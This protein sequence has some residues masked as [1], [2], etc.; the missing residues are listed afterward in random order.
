SQNP[1][2]RVLEIPKMTTL[3]VLLAEDDDNDVIL[4]ETAFRAADISNPLRVT[5]DGQDAIDYLSGAGKFSDRI[6]NPLPCL[7]ILDL[8]MPRRTGIEVLEW[9]RGCQGL[10]RIPTVFLSSSAHAYDVERAYEL[11][12]NGFLVKPASVKAR[13]DL[14]RAIKSFWLDFN[15]PP[16]I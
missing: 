16:A 3:P 15:L 12:A 1:R 7:I 11:G 4:L 5:R 6:G 8:K 13:A 2:S 10:K 14:A 9:L